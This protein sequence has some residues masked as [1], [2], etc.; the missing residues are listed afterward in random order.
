MIQILVIVSLSWFAI[1]L[2]INTPRAWAAGRSVHGMARWVTLAWA[3][4]FVALGLFFGREGK[5]LG[6]G[7]MDS[8]AWF[9]V[10][11]VGLAGTILFVLA[12]N[13][14]VIGNLWRL[15]IALL[16]I[17]GLLGVFSATYS[18]APAISAYKGALI[19]IDSLLVAAAIAAFDPKS[20]GKALLNVSYF[21]AT[22][23]AASSLLGA[24]IDPAA[25]LR[26]STGALGFMLQGYYPYMNPN[27]LGF[28]AAVVAIV[29][30]NRFLQ[31]GPFST[32]FYWAGQLSV[33]LV[34][35]FL[36][37]A[38]TSLLSFIICVIFLSLAVPGRRWMASVA[39]LV[40]MMTVSYS[41]ITGKLPGWGEGVLE[42]AAQYAERGQSAGGLQTLQDR[43]KMWFS[44]GL[45][46][47][48]DKPILGHGYDA[49]V[50]FGA[51]KYGLRMG[52]MHNAHF[53]I[54]A[55]SGMLGYVLWL[56]MVAV[57]SWRM[58]RRLMWDHWPATT[59]EDRFFAEMFAVLLLTL[60][61]T[62]TGQVL[63]T[64]QWSLLLFL[65]TVVCYY[66]RQ[67][68]GAARK[69]TPAPAHSGPG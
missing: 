18:P 28:L 26:P 13:R 11:C 32:R 45:A 30:F 52:H 60:L 69:L 39:A 17:Y 59:G 16:F 61:R 7:S 64:H 40:V 67:H 9:Q 57:V 68:D 43:A 58:A 10:V 35:L 36:A 41:A 5:V 51:K 50:R 37:Q 62:I 2:A 47:I 19:V 31:K 12:F 22:M 27:E 25:A 48:D 66:C 46:M 29:A 65:G 49:G 55:N 3:L 4:M 56:L 42:S 15:P 8:S 33:G 6:I 34:V 53:Q 63:V 38:R 1:G 20:G 24:I 44:S 23:I 21:L 14:R 54:L